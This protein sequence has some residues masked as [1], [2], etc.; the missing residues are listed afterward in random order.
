MHLKKISVSILVILFTI[1]AC[2]PLNAA[3]QTNQS[4]IST[5][6]AA[7]MQALSPT[8]V[9]PTEVP[10][11]QTT[12]LSGIS[13]NFENINIIIPDGLASGATS[14]KF[15]ADSADTMGGGWSAYT[16][17]TLN[18]Y[19]LQGTMVP[20][21]IR[22]FLT[23]EFRLRDP[24]VNE[25]MDNLKSILSNPNNSLDNLP[26]LPIQFAARH[27]QT[28]AKAINFQN[29]SGIRYLTQF[30]Q[31]PAIVSNQEMFYF[32]MGLSQDGK[33]F[34]SAYLPVS[35]AFLPA[36]S[37]P[38]TALPIDGIPY[39]SSNELDTYYATVAEKL[40]GTDPS[41]FNPALPVLDAL[42]QS[43]LIK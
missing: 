9:A 19:P 20:P 3:P 8:Q 22:I 6:V 26:I 17:F 7:T 41:A 1:S 43:I 2:N 18:S 16:S 30:D 25:Q 14:E 31:Y 27:F 13:I 12:Q 15:P 38:Q 40:N 21:V 37:N 29:G 23:E 24:I 10:P 5:V 35:A 4:S 33:Y 42:I 32:F 28:Q 36:D 39:P 34:V 11:T